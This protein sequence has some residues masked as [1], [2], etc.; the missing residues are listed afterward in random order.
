[1]KR[2]VYV[3]LVGAVLLGVSADVQ[4]QSIRKLRKKLNATWQAQDWPGVCDATK[5]IGKLN[6]EKAVK[7]IFEVALRIER[8]DVYDA[9]KEA[10][11]EITDEEA[12]AYL[13][14]QARRNRK[15][16]VRLLVIEVLAKKDAE[17]V[18]GTLVECLNDR[19]PEVV[20]E[21]VWAL[22]TKRDYKAVEPL[23]G[24]LGRVEKDKGR[25][26][27]ETR[28]TL[29]T[30]TGADYRTAEDWKRYWVIRKD[31]LKASPQSP[32]TAPPPKVGEPKTS[33]EEERKKA[34]KFFGQEIM[35]KK[36]MFVIDRSQSM[37]AR[38]PAFKKAE[39]GQ[40]LPADPNYKPGSKDPWGGDTSLPANR[41]RIERVK[42]ELC[43]CIAAMDP[44]TKFS[45]IYFSDTIMVWQKNLVLAGSQSKKAA[46]SWVSR[47]TPM[48]S[49]HTDYALQKA[50]ENKEFDTLF[51]LTDGQPFRDRH[52]LPVDPILAWVRNANRQR[53][54]RIFTFGFAG[55][56][57]T[58]S[59]NPEEMLKLLRGL[60]QEHNGKF[61][62]IYW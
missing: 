50:F 51:L 61:T 55:V 1:M 48:G 52:L 36:I 17:L 14:K 33:L 28:R 2:V 45:V 44:K 11:G 57:K 10:L 38:D 19:K 25:L 29:T 53:K 4:A 41:A 20:R 12:I 31:E 40:L 24:L 13:C 62:N 23:I 54:V 34:P 27:V 18:F 39:G 42:V 58:S 30:L 26:W 22:K 6:S 35:S 56:E 15:W 60:A 5:E 8:K 43:K 3:L 59:V 9:A 46:I 7:L 47:L 37:Q 16:E 49:T 21:A 32:D